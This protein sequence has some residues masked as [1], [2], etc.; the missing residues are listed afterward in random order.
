MRSNM[1]KNIFQ[2]ILLL[3]LLSSNV[4]A[5]DNRTLDTKIADILAQMPTDDLIHRDRVMGELVELGSQGF[6][7]L[8]Q[9]LTPAGEGDDTAVRFAIN[10]LSR[11]ASE[12]GR[13]Q[14]KQ[15]VEDN[16]LLGI[17]NTENKDVK[18]FLIRQLNLVASEK[19]LVLLSSLLHDEQL[20]EPAAQ[21]LL[22]MRDGAVAK[23]F[24]KALDGAEGK[25]KLT[26]IRALGELQC[27]E[28]ADPV[29][30]F[31]NTGDNALKK[32]SQAALSNIGSATS[33]KP[34]LK[35][36]QAVNF[37]YEPSNAAEAFIHY[38][39]RL[40]E[41]GEFDLCKKAC[42]AIIKANQSQDLLHNYAGALSIYT[43]WF[44]YEAIP[45][46]LK[47]A[48]NPD[49][50]FRY[51]VLNLAEDQG[52][53]AGTR[54]WI[55]K[56][57]GASGPSK[58]DIVDM[59]G[60]RGDAAAIPFVQEQLKDASTEVREEAISAMVKLSG[61]AAVPVLIGHLV[62]GQDLGAT[63]QALLQLVDNKH[64]GPV[65]AHMGS[66]SG[67]TKAAIVDIIAAKSGQLHSEEIL[68][69]TGSEDP[70]ERSAAF[71]ALKR[72]CSTQELDQLIDLLLSV[73]SGEEIDKV[74]E[75]VV[76]VCKD[77]EGDPS[78]ELL[79]GWGQQIQKSAS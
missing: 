61:S 48:D 20:S 46:L 35:A 38:A 31:L 67:A 78:A 32:V 23:A 74:Q 73:D 60:R 56:A 79:A 24:L 72:V 71:S 70:A 34:L 45:L 51:A 16:L 58:A 14:A 25:N 11:Y 36:A 1:I 47:A 52:G 55:A 42:N 33:Y 44:G 27:A 50:A 19:S 4:I 76:A 2:P 22:S 15:Y 40:G 63:K 62:K 26:I 28:A 68:A 66:T 5:Q 77:L 59:L 64:L 53:V 75:A 3:F 6:D 49:K 21:A 41:Q 37:G 54:Q 7:K 30:A 57:T 17:G 9:Q 65:A 43:R 18:T 8:L 12:F 29:A 10:S 13:E 39:D 69:L